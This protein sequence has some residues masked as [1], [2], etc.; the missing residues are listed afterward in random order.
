MRSRDKL[1][2]PTVVLTTIQ[3]QIIEMITKRIEKLGRDIRN[4]QILI[5]HKSG[6]SP[7]TN[8]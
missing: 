2:K 1:N 7:L 5:L 3:F 6:L 4:N 8:T